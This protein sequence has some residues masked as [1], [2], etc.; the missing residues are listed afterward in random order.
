MDNKYCVYIHRNKSNG[1]QYC[2]ITSQKPEYRWRKGGGY[3]HNTHFQNAISKYGWDGF[4]HHII[5]SGLSRDEA[6]CLEKEYISKFNLTNPEFG[7][8]HTNGGDGTEGYS[9]TDETKRKMSQSRKGHICTEDTKQ[10]ISD[11]NSGAGNGMYGATPWNKG[12][13]MSE[14]TKQKVSANRKGKTAGG[15]HPMYGKRH[16]PESIKKMS[17]SHKGCKAW[18]KG[19]KTGIKPSNSKC[20]GMYT[21]D[22]ALLREYPSVTDAARDVGNHSGNISACCKGK[23]KHA[24]GYVWK[25]I[26]KDVS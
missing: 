5:H 8:N 3:I 21:D 14:E 26:D 4:E 13:S 18:N 12:L 20:V 2:G 23:V 22:G 15:S 17:A 16:T 19:I 1:K 10:K 7:Y 24:S 6:N 11:K 9:H 25:Y